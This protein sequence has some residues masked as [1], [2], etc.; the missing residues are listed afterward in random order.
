MSEIA[1]EI[2]IA[3]L[4]YGYLNNFSENDKNIEEV[5][6]AY[7]EIYKQVRKCHKEN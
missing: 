5:K 2:V 3:M 1:K 7:E 6:K 4:Q